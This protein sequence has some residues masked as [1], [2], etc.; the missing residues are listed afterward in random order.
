MLPS[1]IREDPAGLSLVEDSPGRPVA[2]CRPVAAHGRV[3]EITG[4]AD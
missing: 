1:T 4:A 3:R 2:T